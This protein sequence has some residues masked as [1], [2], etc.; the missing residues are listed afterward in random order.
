[1]A[2]I[3]KLA[4][5]AYKMTP[6]RKAALAKAVAASAKKRALKG[7]GKVVAKKITKKAAVKSVKKVT[8]VSRK[9]RKATAR[10]TAIDKV[11]K[12]GL[13]RTAKGTKIGGQRRIS[14]SNFKGAKGKA[15]KKSTYKA[16][17]ESSRAKYKQ[18]S[19]KNRV[20]QKLI[21]GVTPTGIWRR[22]Y[23]DLTVG[24]N[25]RRNVSRNLKVSAAIAPASIAANVAA[26]KKLNAMMT[27]P[28]AAKPK[29]KKKPQTR[30]GK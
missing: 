12:M 30:R 8:K 16:R 13:K 24:E 2:I 7:G 19:V 26:T 3:G 23:A 25:V 28:P 6:K 21:G 14:R 11:E 29:K 18:S 4:K 10:K 20:G 1:M 22:K 5:I 17:L 9:V 15:L 27:P